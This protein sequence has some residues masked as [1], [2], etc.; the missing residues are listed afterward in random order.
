VGTLWREP[1]GWA[2]LL[3][4][5]EDRQKRLRRCATLSIGASLRNLE[6]G[7]STGE[8]ERWMKGALIMELFCLKRLSAEGLW[9]IC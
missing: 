5:L 3:A 2:L 4:I 9:K 1:G 8:F 7:L 6:G